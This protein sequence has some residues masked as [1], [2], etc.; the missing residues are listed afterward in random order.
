MSYL[1]VVYRCGSCHHVL[2]EFLKV[3][4]DSYGLPTPS[5]LI[6]KIGDHCPNCGKKLRLPTMENIRIA[7]YRSKK[8]PT[9]GLIEYQTK[10]Q[11][12]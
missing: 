9:S 8:T 6:A 11:V 12:I 10:S 1:P 3:G 7:P 2:Y 4:Q 5:E